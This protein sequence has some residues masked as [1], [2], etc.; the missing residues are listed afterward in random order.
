M[1]ERYI[2][3][4][5]DFPKPGIVFKDITPLLRS[6]EGLQLAIDRLAEAAA[7]YEFD[8]V[9]GVESR[10]FIF[11]TALARQL[12]TGFVPIRKPG[13]LPCATDSE[14]YELEYG[15]D[16]LEIHTDALEGAPRVLMVDDLLATGGTMDAA[17]RL[18]RKVGGTPVS[19]L[20]VIELG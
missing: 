15:S 19:C 12:G 7:A 2:R 6:A 13:K 20:F 17:L 9:S 1:I 3:D 10:G 14:S 18:V 5:P 16:S 11:G 4:V 8:I